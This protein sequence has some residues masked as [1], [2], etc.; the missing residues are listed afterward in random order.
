MSGDVG[1]FWVDQ[2]H[3]IMAGM[4]VADGVDDGQCVNGPDDHDPY[5]ETVQRTHVHLWEVE[6]YQVPWGRVLFNKA[7][8]RFYVYLDMV[9]CTNRIKRRILEHFHLPRKRS[10][11]RTDLHYTTGADELDRLYSQ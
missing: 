7:E 10:S 2:D 9:L 3:L 1:I 8:H 5:W 4:P 6:Y 11:F